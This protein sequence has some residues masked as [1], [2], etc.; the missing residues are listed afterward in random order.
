[1]KPR[2]L[3]KVLPAI[4]GLAAAGA[5]LWW[6]YWP[7]GPDGELVQV[8]AFGANPTAL[9]MHLYVPPRVAP[10]P[11][12]LLALHWCTGSGP[13]FFAETGYAELADELGFIV[14][15]PSAT[16]AGHCWDVHSTAALT[17]GGGSDP[18]G[19]LAMI[20][21]V[22]ER[23]HADRARVFVAGHSSGGMMTQVLLGA[24]PDVFRAGAATAGVPFGCFAGDSEW[25]EECARGRVVK[26]AQEWA[27]LVWRAAPAFSGPRPR[28]QLWHGT[29]DEALDFA[30]FAEAIKQW[31]RVLG[32]G[33]T[34]VSIDR[35]T[36]ARHWTRQR[37]ATPAGE[38]RLEAHRGDAVPHDFRTPEREVMRFFGLAAARGS[39][40]ATQ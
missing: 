6:R 31:T 27:E 39:A 9:D 1:M 29:A 24:Y 30:N 40:N 5:M 34:P 28:L 21:H 13:V 25:Q 2:L 8:T 11:A 33:D 10:N 17:H 16:R 32:T 20:G 12:V 35:D 19:L 7:P 23:H 26:S 18:Q 14:I 38:V 37:Y 3:K 36:P 22:V 4:A 15:Y